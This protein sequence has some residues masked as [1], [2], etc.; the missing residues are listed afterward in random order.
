MTVCSAGVYPCSPTQSQAY[1]LQWRYMLW[2]RQPPV[3][4]DI[5]P[6]PSQDQPP[7]SMLVV[8]NHRILLYVQDCQE[9]ASQPLIHLPDAEPQTVCSLS[10]T[11]W[12]MHNVASNPWYGCVQEESNHKPPQDPCSAYLWFPSSHPLLS[13]CQAPHRTTYVPWY[14]DCLPQYIWRHHTLSRNASCQAACIF[15]GTKQYQMHH[16]R[17]PPEPQMCNVIC[18]ISHCCQDSHLYE[19]ENSKPHL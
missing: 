1:P 10:G 13:E 2:H 18:G 17:N 7:C 5:L 19:Q 3:E 16:L 6:L 4:K 12:G 9:R 11:C 15:H 14:D 8:W